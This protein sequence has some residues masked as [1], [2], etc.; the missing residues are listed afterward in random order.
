MALK[1]VW[2]EKALEGLD[3]IIEYLETHW[4]EKEILLLEQKIEAF[5][6]RVKKYPKIYPLLGKYKNTHKAVLDK[7][8]YFVYRYKPRKKVI[9]LV[10][11]RASKQKPII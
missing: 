7:H 8:N 10:Y 9:E 2:T 1:I 5:K 11:F 6:S 4:T 3:E